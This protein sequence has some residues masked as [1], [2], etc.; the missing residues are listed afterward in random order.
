MFEKR[1]VHSMPLTKGTGAFSYHKTNGK[2]PISHYKAR[3][4]CR[5]D[6]APGPTERSILL[7]SSLKSNLRL[8]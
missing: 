8:T 4:R 6:V 1:D 3:Y 5:Y 2:K 7:N